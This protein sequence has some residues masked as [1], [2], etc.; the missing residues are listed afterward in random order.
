MR[1]SRR[2]PASAPSA[3][4]GLDNSVT[5]SAEN[6]QRSRGSRR[7]EEVITRDV[8]TRT[9]SRLVETT[10]EPPQPVEIQ[11]GNERF[12]SRRTLT[13]SRNRPVEEGTESTPRENVLRNRPRSNRRPITTITPTST[14][15]LI[16]EATP[17]IDE[18]KIEIINTNLNDISRISPT[19][20]IPTTQ[21]RRRSSVTVGQTTESVLKS[22]R[23]DVRRGRINTRVNI[24]PLEIDA[25]GTTNSLSYVNKESTTARTNDLRNSRKLRYRQR[26]P[27]TDTN[28]TGDGFDA[29]NEV[30]SSQI[31][32][33]PSQVE[34]Q[35]ASKEILISQST[36]RSK[37]K[38]TTIKVTKVVRRPIGRGKANH[39][40]AATLSKSKSS[41]EINEDDNYPESFKALIQAKNASVS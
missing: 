36:E 12:D 19:Q 9:R 14:T 11:S 1:Y 26:Q 15:T 22:T 29:I 20:E 5:S 37:F 7:R 38:T 31:K 24:K 28:L 8:R 34:D 32:E 18:S 39:R 21:Y 41:E 35:V 27:D 6:Q 17:T 30:K 33:I 16:Y 40:Q 13:R 4:S 2:L 23:R 10:S 3:P 25:S